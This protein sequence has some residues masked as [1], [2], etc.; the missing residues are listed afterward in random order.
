MKLID[1]MRALEI[2]TEEQKNCAPVTIKIGTTFDKRVC[3]NSLVITDCP[4]K[5]LNVLK[6]EGFHFSMHEGELH[7]DKH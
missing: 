5:I 3:H 2:I 7:I 1:K 4:A 6:E